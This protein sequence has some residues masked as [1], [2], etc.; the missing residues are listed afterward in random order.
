VVIVSITLLLI[1]AVCSV[2]AVNFIKKQL[3]P[4]VF[5]EYV[6]KYSNEFSVPEELVYAV[7]RCESDFDPNAKS[8]V[9]ANGLMQL[10][11]STLEWLSALLDEEAPT[12]EITDP[13]TN[14]KYGT[15]YLNYLYQKFGSWETALAA[16]NAGHGRVAEW[17]EDSEYSE[18]GKT[19]VKIP[20][21][22]TR[23][24]VNRVMS[25]KEEYHSLYYKN[26]EK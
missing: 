14:I 23:N 3:Y 7:I 25:A 12:G 6:E 26:G 8:H 21:E 15:F 19:L 1:F 11:P 24:Y 10:M 9:G 18:D 20:F 13:E 4:R 16:Y 22:E 5:N 17:L 2:F